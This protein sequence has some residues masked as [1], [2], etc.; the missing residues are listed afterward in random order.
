MDSSRKK[1]LINA[2]KQKPKNGGVFA[3]RSTASDMRWIEC[4]QDLEGMKNR[5]E[6]SVSTNVPIHYCLQ[7]DWKTLGASTFVYEVLE[8]VPQK[9]G[10]LPGDYQRGLELLR[11]CLREECPAEKRY[12]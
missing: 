2:Y 8:T 12:Q 4:T 10:E 1:E 6:F 9:E 3:I 7:E 5:F 11:D